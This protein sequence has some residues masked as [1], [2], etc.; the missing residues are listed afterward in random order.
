MLPCRSP[1]LIPIHTK[2]IAQHL[3]EFYHS[4]VHNVFLVVSEESRNEVVSQLG[5]LP[6]NV[7]VCGI[8]NSRGVGATL[9]WALQQH[10]LCEEV[11]VN[12][13]TTLPSGLVPPHS[14]GAAVVPEWLLSQ[15]AKV[16]ER[17][18][19][20]VAF[21]SRSDENP[22]SAKAFTGLFRAETERLRECVPRFQSSNDLVIAPKVLQKV[23]T[24]F[25][26]WEE[27]WIDC[28]HDAN[29]PRARANLITSRSFNSLEVDPSQ[30]TIRKS[31]SNLDKIRREREYFQQLPSE[32][33]VHFP[34]LRPNLEDPKNE[35]SYVMEY[36]G[37]PNLAELALC[38]KLPEEAWWR[39]F[40]GL[41]GM[42]SQFRSISAPLDKENYLR[43]FLTK[44]QQ[45]I[46]EYLG[47][48]E[49]DERLNLEGNL[50]VDG[51]ALQ[52]LESV[53]ENYESLIANSFEQSALTVFHGDLCFNNIL[54]GWSEG[55][56]R[57]IDPRGGFDREGIHGDFRYDLAKV[58]HSACG[59]YDLFV[60][61]RFEL[62]EG[63]GEASLQ[64]S[65]SKDGPNF[66]EM[67]SWL[68]KQQRVESRFVQAVTGSLFLSMC[69]LHKED[70]VRQRAFFIHG[71]RMLS[72]VLN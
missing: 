51:V 52:S 60:A 21:Y 47:S 66:T 23:G 67:M 2:P 6:D 19:G 5:S 18:N 39:L 3:I 29:L 27:P 7:T 26:I 31:S 43:F 59:H 14:V 24:V 8:A 28:G 42:M 62:K 20:E 16:T 48:L 68:L 44:T 11:I 22:T 53:L 49:K 54:Y 17:K 46:E 33:E 1:A 4:R 45:R 71:R 36:V 61:N 56:I 58:N 57:L 15:L 40:E 64:F 12:V 72:E 35:Q 65:L 55:I 63:K 70:P 37:Y 25:E 32:L 13:V 9:A 38:W 50:I 41:S 69:P 34:R 30:Q 10:D